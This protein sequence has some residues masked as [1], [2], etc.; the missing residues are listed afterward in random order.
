MNLPHIIGIAGRKGAGKSTM[1]QSIAQAAVGLY[2][3]RIESFAGPL[4]SLCALLFGGNE[5]WFQATQA[6]KEAPIWELEGFEWLE[7]RLPEHLQSMRAL[8]QQIGTEGVRDVLPT[9]WIL[10]MERRCREAA[11]RGRN[12]VIIDDVRFPDEAAWVRQHGILAH[13]QREDLAELD[14]HISER[15]IEPAPG[16][17][18]C[19]WHPQRN[20]GGDRQAFACKMLAEIGR[21]TT[22][23][24]KEVS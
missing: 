5:H 2:G 3:P 12:L 10:C 15:G 4:R 14:Q 6:E 21:R 24:A 18:I 19:R 9:A 22:T 20:G 16:E 7:G 13:L 11:E 1:A 23:Q 17:L 8:L